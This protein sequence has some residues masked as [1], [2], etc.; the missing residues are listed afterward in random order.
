MPTI[1]KLAPAIV[2]ALAGCTSLHVE[3]DYDHTARFD[4]MRTFAFVSNPRQ[5]QDQPQTD[6]TARLEDVSMVNNSIVRARI[7]DA[8]AENL[9]GKGFRLVDKNPDML[10]GYYISSQPVT[11]VTPGYGFDYGYG[12]D[13]G[14]GYGFRNRYNNGGWDYGYSF[15]PVTSIPTLD[16]EHYEEGTLLIDIVDP[17][18]K[19]L[20]WRGRGE[21]DVDHA[22]ELIVSKRIRKTVNGILVQFPPTD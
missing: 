11:T 18:N 6:K 2:L 7:R 15:D 9:S 17:K 4:G 8:I 5:V 20:L 13:Y 22:S 21:R 3:T 1:K 12:I 10:V 19:R 14:Y 16:V